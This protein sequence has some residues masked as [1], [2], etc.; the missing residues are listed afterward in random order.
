[1]G[2]STEI[3][4]LCVVGGFLALDTTAAWQVMLS[5]PLV[6][7]TIAG[8]MIGLPQIGVFIG[9][10]LQLLWSG[11]IPVGAR[12]MPDAVAGSISGVWF[13]STLL[14]SSGHSS[15]SFC[16]LL[17]LIAGMSIGLLGTQTIILERSVCRRLFRDVMRRISLG[18]AVRLEKTIL[19]AI[20]IGFA[21]G[22]FLC[23]AAIGIL[24]VF[25]SLVQGHESLF[26]RD[27]SIVILALEALGVGVLISVFVGRSR[28]RLLGLVGCMLW[29]LVLT[30][31]FRR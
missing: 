21:R 24:R 5:Q 2:T 29:A 7:G 26:N 16:C 1:M 13:A 6:S 15:L 30:N 9:L 14:K 28:G 11:A 22:F 3:L 31:L 4:L 18:E 17:G 10:V 8:F 23:L 20:A 19:V 27:Y 12:P 25:V